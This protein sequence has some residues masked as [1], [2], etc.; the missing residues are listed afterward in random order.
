MAFTQTQ[1]DRLEEAIAEGVLEVKYQ[2]RTVRYRS[3]NQ[4]IQLREMM[5][6]EL[7]KRPKTS[8]VYTKFKKGTC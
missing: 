1:L 6:R 2:D 4:M 5:R 8:R 3:L 7:G